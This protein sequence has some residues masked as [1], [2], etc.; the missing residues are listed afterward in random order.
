M[1]TAITLL[2]A[3]VTSI[4]LSAPLAL[5]DLGY[6]GLASTLIGSVWLIGRLVAVHRG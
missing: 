1:R 6:I 4:L 2:L 5:P 3:G